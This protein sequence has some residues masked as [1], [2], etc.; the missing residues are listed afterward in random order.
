VLRKALEGVFE[1]GPG[2]ARVA[3]GQGAPPAFQQRR[4]VASR[5]PRGR[6]DLVI[7]GGDSTV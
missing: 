3:R 1:R 7:D 6:R 2:L 5:L 4:E